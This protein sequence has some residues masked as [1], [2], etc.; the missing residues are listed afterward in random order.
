[1]VTQ[2][3]QSTDNPDVCLLV[4]TVLSLVHSSVDVHRRCVPQRLGTASYCAAAG[5]VATCGDRVRLALIG[6]VG[7]HWALLNET[8]QTLGVDVDAA[9][10]PSDLIVIQVGDL[11]DRGPDS[12]GCVEVADTLM[13]GNPGRWVQLLGNH[14]GNRIGGPHF[15]DEDLDDLTVATLQRWWEERTARL[16]IG[17][18]TVDL[19]D[20]L[21][22]HGGLTRTLW[23]VLGQPSLTETVH[24]LNSWVGRQADLAFAAGVM[25]G[26][27]GI[28]G[29]V[30]S[31]ALTELYA[32]WSRAAA[33]PYGQVHG[34][35]A[36]CDW[37]A[38]RLRRDADP[39]VREAADIDTDARRTRVEI[40]GRPFIGIDPAF[41]VESPPVGL[42]ALVLEGEI[43]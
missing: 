37:D 8:L 4:T 13:A 42:S 35:S 6:D 23:Q 2:G 21:V 27:G 28:A 11:I 34:H 22:S 24:V 14:E 3:G 5:T 7:G 40:G 33:V 43:L 18:R 30:W 41:G 31:D 26:P 25:L 38:G 19:G 32:S 29:P 17:I 16:A 36:I 1:M 39:W 20:L 15:W 10:M 12:A 9:E